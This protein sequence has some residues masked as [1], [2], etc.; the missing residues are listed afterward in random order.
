MIAATFFS[1]QVSLTFHGC[2]TTLSMTGDRRS[3]GARTPGSQTRITLLIGDEL[4]PP[5]YGALIATPPLRR[6]FCEY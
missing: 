5:T 1:Y 6:F 2:R 3:I 4:Q